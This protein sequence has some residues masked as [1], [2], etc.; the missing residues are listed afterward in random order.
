MSVLCADAD[1]APEGARPRR[2]VALLALCALAPITA[3]IL[4]GAGAVAIAP[5]AI[6]E[7]VWGMVVGDAA[8][9]A[10]ASRE[11]LVLANIRLPRL[12]DLAFWSL[13]GLAGASWTKVHALAPLAIAVLVAVGFLARGLDALALGEAEAFPLGV[14]VQRLKIAVVGL[15]ALA[16]GGSVAAAGLVGFVGIVVPH[17]LRLAVGPGHAL[18]PPLSAL[19]GATLPMGA[20]ALARVVVAPAE[21]PLGVVTAALG[22]PFF[23]W[24]LL[25]RGGDLE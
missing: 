7:T 8:A 11:A 3:T 13:G 22:A 23:L 24:M 17:V 2:G 21:L 25:R 4:L 15:T 18:L 20:D 19:G 10:A 12:R 14:P 6:V 9:A 1:A 16:V 5:A